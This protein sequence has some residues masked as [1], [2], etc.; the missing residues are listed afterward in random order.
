MPSRLNVLLVDDDP[1]IAQAVRTFLP[2]ERY[3]V[4]IV[5]D[6]ARVMDA[7]KGF[8]PD[9]VLLDVHLPSVSGLELLRQIKTEVS[10]VPVV[11]ISG[12]VSTGNAIEAMKEG[13]FEYLTK[14]F[15]L[16]QLEK[17]IARAVGQIAPK[18]VIADDD[19]PLTEGQIIGKSPEIV[20]VAKIIGQIAGTEAPV[21]VMGE[22]GTG[23]ELVARAIHRNSPRSTQPFVIVNC[24]STEE[25][26]LESELFGQDRPVSSPSFLRHPGR[27]EQANGGTVFLDEVADLSLQIQS[28]LLRLLQEQTI[29]RGQGLETAPI[30]IR[31]IAATNRSLVD[32]MK[33]GRFRVDLFYR[34]KVISLFLPPLRERRADIPLLSDFFIKKYSRASGC[35]PK[36][37]SEG[38]RQCLARHAWPGNVR[39]LENVIHTAVVLSKEH[40]LLPEDFPMIQG[41]AATIAWAREQPREDYLELFRQTLAPA[42]E[43]IL[44]CSEGHVHGELTDALEQVLVE[45]ALECTGNNQVRS[46]QLLGISRNTLRDRL[47]KFELSAPAPAGGEQ[48]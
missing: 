17:T 3:Q 32:L 5:V 29:D 36:P 20:H 19:V 1:E 8:Q 12:Y 2:P 41:S 45:T 6:G 27:F 25:V 9:L 18:T 11:I 7:V 21:L 16:E 23:K 30:D 38:A 46:A 13:A 28:K 44:S 26:T 40:E 34:L 31:I 39:E 14:P 10:R 33:E 4:E 24:A 47:K 15:R 48:A 22:T 37:L 42:F 35:Q 43:H